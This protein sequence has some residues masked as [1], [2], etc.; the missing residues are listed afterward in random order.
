MDA[1]L[2]LAVLGWLVFPGL[3]AT[4]LLEIGGHRRNWNSTC[5]KCYL[6]E[7]EPC[8][9]DS[10]CPGLGCSEANCRSCGFGPFAPCPPHLAVRRDARLARGDSTRTANKIDL[11]QEGR[12]TCDCNPSEPCFFDPACPGLGCGAISGRPKCRFCG[13]GAFKG[14]ACP[15]I[16]RTTT[17]TY[18]SKRTKLAV[19]RLNERFRIGTPSN[20]LQAAGV[21]MHASANYLNAALMAKRGT[22]FWSAFLINSH[23]HAFEDGSL[24]I[25][26]K[27]VGSHISRPGVVLAPDL[28]KLWCAYPTD[29]STDGDEAA[30]RTVLTHHGDG[31]TPLERP[32]SRVLH[33]QLCSQAAAEQPAFCKGVHKCVPGCGGIG[34]DQQQSWFP[35]Q[36]LKQMMM[37]SAERT[38]NNYWNEVAHCT[39]SSTPS[40]ANI[41]P[42]PPLPS[43]AAS[44]YSLLTTHYS[45]LTTHYSRLTAHYLLLTSHF[46]LLTTQYSLLPS[47]SSLLTTHCSLLTHHYSLLTTHYSLLTTHF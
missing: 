1:P 14:I 35:P 33:Q 4:P 20:D 46:S 11:P 12:Q 28:V 10:S 27:R 2:L 40:P 42:H 38:S 21:L 39:R 17:T 16:A 24:A 5:S 34:F 6:S 3:A 9:F 13:F 32:P 19:N 47:H 31:L 29:G 26:G 43:P 7:Q 15:E 44:H 30:C 45:L 23:S 41:P 18:N 25:Y 37:S 8:F 22:L 36:R